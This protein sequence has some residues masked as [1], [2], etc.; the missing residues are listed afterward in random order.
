MENGCNFWGLVAMRN[1]GHLGHN[2]VCHPEIG[3]KSQSKAGFPTKL[4]LEVAGRKLSCFFWF[5]SNL[6]IP[7]CY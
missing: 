5:K 2:W 1:L 6:N 3:K 7:S 4:F